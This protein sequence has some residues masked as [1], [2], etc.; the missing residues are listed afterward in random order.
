[1]YSENEILWLF[2]WW[3]LFHC[4]SSFLFLMA[5]GRTTIPGFSHLS[6]PSLTAI[7][8]A[9]PYNMGATAKLVLESK[10]LPA[11]PCT[12][13]L[14][15]TS[16]RYLLSLSGTCTLAEIHPFCSVLSDCWQ[17]RRASSILLTASNVEALHWSSLLAI[18]RSTTQLLLTYGVS[19]RK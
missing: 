18:S 17:S 9:I 13:R 19:C 2:S 12:V 7:V 11:V 6:F 14:I 3:S 10:C 1:M 4:S 8:Y 16:I 15:L 5:D